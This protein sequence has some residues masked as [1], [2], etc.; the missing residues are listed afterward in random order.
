MAARK[1]ELVGGLQVQVAAV[2]GGERHALP[3]V[4]VEIVVEPVLAV[5]AAAAED[6]D[7]VSA[8]CAGLDGTVGTQL[9]GLRLWFQEAHL[10]T[11]HGVGIGGMEVDLEAVLRHHDGI[12][13]HAVNAH[14]VV[15]WHLRVILLIVETAIEC[16]PYA[17]IRPQ[18]VAFAVELHGDAV[19]M[20]VVAKRAVERDGQVVLRVHARALHEPRHAGGM[21]RGRHVA[22]DIGHWG[23]GLHGLLQV[24][25]PCEQRLVVVTT[26]IVGHDV[27]GAGVQVVGMG[28]AEAADHA[29]GK[30]VLRL[31]KEAAL[32]GGQ[33]AEHVAARRLV[34]GIGKA[35]EVAHHTHAVARRLAPDA[36]HGAEAI[37]GQPLHA[38]LPQAGAVGQ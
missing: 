14:R 23:I 33:F 11:G 12:A 15:G 4:V 5:C 7:I 8:L 24:A 1:G 32:D 10:R 30:Q 21:K 3:Q 9:Q 6:V 2:G 27:D 29:V 26:G 34:Y 38:P 17:R 20:L 22:A 18:H 16:L 25:E 13:R 19:C 28:V 36:A 31:G 37:V 35:D